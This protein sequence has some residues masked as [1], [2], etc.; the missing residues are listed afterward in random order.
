VIKLS[1]RLPRLKKDRFFWYIVRM[2]I[3]DLKID[4]TA[5]SVTSLS[6]PSDE[7]GHW[8]SK[9]PHQRLQAVELMRRIIYGYDPTSTR[10]QRVFAVTQRPSRRISNIQDES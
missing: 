5:F 4:K 1:Q 3:Q 10:L 7:K 8:L 2:N 6:A 9:T